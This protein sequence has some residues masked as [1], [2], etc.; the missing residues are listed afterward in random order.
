MKEI[1]LLKLKAFNI[2]EL[3]GIHKVLYYLA[4]YWVITGKPHCSVLHLDMLNIKS[5]IDS[6]QRLDL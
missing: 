6:I 4:I 5:L 2:I 1:A 3:S